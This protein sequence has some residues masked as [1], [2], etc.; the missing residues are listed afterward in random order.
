MSHYLHLLW[1]NCWKWLASLIEDATV[2]SLPCSFTLV[3]SAQNCWCWNGQGSVSYNPTCLPPVNCLVREKGIFGIAITCFSFI[4]CIPFYIKRNQSGWR[5]F[6][7]WLVSEPAALGGLLV[8]ALTQSQEGECW[9]RATSLK[10]ISKR[11]KMVDKNLKQE[12]IYW[13]KSAIYLWLA[14]RKVDLL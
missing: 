12:D 9:R 8:G 6:V 1:W 2:L 5:T 11:T 14:P 3:Y 7:I 13:Q 10:N 4:F